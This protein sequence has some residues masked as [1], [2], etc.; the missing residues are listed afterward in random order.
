MGVG[1]LS[2]T[3]SGLRFLRRARQAAGCW[4]I[5]PGCFIKHRGLGSRTRVLTKRA[6]M[7]LQQL[8]GD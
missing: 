8:P 5:H 7:L 3:V 1:Y 2:L 4:E 6:K